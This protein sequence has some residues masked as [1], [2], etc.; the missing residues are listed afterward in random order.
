VTPLGSGG[1]GINL[2]LSIGNPSGVRVLYAVSS[3]KLRSS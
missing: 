1:A 3:K 2:E